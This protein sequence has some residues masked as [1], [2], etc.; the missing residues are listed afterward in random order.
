MGLARA[1]GQAP[2]GLAEAGDRGEHQ[3][4]ERVVRVSPQ[5]AQQPVRGLVIAL[6]WANQGLLI[7]DAVGFGFSRCDALWVG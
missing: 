2:G 4:L 7:G 6:S 5:R 1:I 3:A